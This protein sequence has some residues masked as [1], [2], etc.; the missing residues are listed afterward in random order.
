[1]RRPTR[2]RPVPHRPPAP[3]IDAKGLA[4]EA[5]LHDETFA[6][7]LWRRPTPL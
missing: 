7:Q 3:R 5:E 6:Q 4:A 1:M 2:D